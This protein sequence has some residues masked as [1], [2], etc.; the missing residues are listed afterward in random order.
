MKKTKEEK[1][2]DVQIGGGVLGTTA[3]AEGD[4][5]EVQSWVDYY[6]R[7]YH[8]AGYGTSIREDETVDGTRCVKIHRYNHCN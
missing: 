2:L 7:Q 1:S 6:L 5:E 4:P 8:P 3:I